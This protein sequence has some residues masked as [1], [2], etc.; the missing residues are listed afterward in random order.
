MTKT[1]LPR[2]TSSS[3]A[4]VS[5]RLEA[6][7]T[8]L[9]EQVSTLEELL[10]LYEETATE[11]EQRLQST[12]NDLEKKAQQ[13]EHAQEAL[14]TLQSI[15]DSMGDAVIVVDADSQ[16]L[17]INP[18]AKQLLGEESPDI[19]FQTW[20]QS[21]LVFDTDGET[22]CR[23]EQ[24]PLARALSGEQVDATEMKLVNQHNDCDR[25]L[26]VN[27]R[28]VTADSCVTGAVAVFREVT[29]RKQ[30][31]QDLKR[32]HEAAQAQTCVLE[33]TLIQLKQTQAQLVH[34]E[35]MASLG[36]TVAG[37]AHEINNPVNFIHGN[38]SHT[39]SAFNDLMSLVQHFQKIYD[40]LPE[41]IAQPFRPALQTV[42]E[43]IDLNF[44]VKDIPP[45]LK[46][47][48][49]G[50]HRIKEIVKS[51]RVFSRLD[52]SGIKAVD[53][54]QGI[55]SAIMVVR[56][57]FTKSAN[58]PE[59]TLHRHYEDCGLIKCHANQ[60]N[61][62]F[63]HLLN[64][65]IDA[66]E[67]H[68][69]PTISIHTHVS[70]TTLTIEIADNGH[71]IPNGI[72]SKIFDPFFTTK[73]VGRGTGLGLAIC[74][75]IIVDSHKGTISCFSQEGQGTQFVVTLPTRAMNPAIK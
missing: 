26:S 23:I 11:Q 29:Q 65:A 70:E 74:H 52:E 7:V 38:L 9:K 5:K 54:H 67:T 66:L 30:I 62:V 51:L 56:S 34:G 42:I 72:Q 47:M 25:W 20:S 28:P 6:E 19:S 61:Q 63:V 59:I 73:A 2:E 33:N 27:A 8:A 21:H 22:L 41:A 46:S 58:R 50:T 4:N 68:R 64:N 57:R 40:Q 53:I 18:A 31:E 12:L 36:Q 35:K 10:Q 75:Q 55:D 13:L 43:E 71:G 45:M 37:I 14:Q 17:F 15:L 49:A 39:A 69:A 3:Q 60:L 1:A 48:Q 32:S 44:L 24:S 16:A